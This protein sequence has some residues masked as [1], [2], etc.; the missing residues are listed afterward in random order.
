MNDYNELWNHTQITD[1]PLELYQKF[2]EIRTKQPRVKYDIF[3]LYVPYLIKI[4]LTT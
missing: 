1:S 4:M 3:F 2:Y